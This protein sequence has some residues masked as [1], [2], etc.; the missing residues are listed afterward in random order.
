MNYLSILTTLYL[1][2][3]PI[4]NFF[5]GPL[6][7][8]TKY[9]LIFTLY[10]EL[11]SLLSLLGRLFTCMF[12]N[13]SNSTTQGISNVNLRTWNTQVIYDCIFNLW[14]SQQFEFSAHGS[15]EKFELFFKM[16]GVQSRNFVS[17]QSKRTQQSFS[18]KLVKCINLKLSDEKYLL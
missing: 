18:A 7:I 4:S 1:E 13:L 14:I 16:D 2:H 6:N 12:F 15:N 3:P 10:L 11:F 5:P 8:S 9:T 17:S